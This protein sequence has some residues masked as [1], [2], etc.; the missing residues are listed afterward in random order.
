MLEFAT[1]SVVRDHI[2][3]NQAHMPAPIKSAALIGSYL[4]RQCGIATFTDD[5]AAA[6]TANDSDINCTIVRRLLSGMSGRLMISDRSMRS[7]LVA[8]FPIPFNP[9][10]RAA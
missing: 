4:P 7:P 8:I 2:H 10:G 1:P 3:W 9:M 5:L 6:I